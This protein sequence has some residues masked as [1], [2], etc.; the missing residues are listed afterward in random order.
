MSEITSVVDEILSRGARK[1]LADHWHIT[2]QAVGI[3]FSPHNG[4]TRIS[5]ALADLEGIAEVDP[6]GW[7]KLE[8]LLTTL[9]ASWR[10]GSAKSNPEK[11]LSLAS[12]EFSDVVSAQL[13]GLPTHIRVKEALEAIAVLQGYVQSY[14]PRKQGAVSKPRPVEMK[15][16]RLRG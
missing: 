7:A 3:R 12:R 6:D 8:I 13:D 16:V 10:K 14:L 15:K 11:C 4:E 9:F 1:H 5:R 2:E